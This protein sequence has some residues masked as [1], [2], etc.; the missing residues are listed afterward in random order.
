MTVINIDKQSFLFYKKV[1]IDNRKSI[2]MKIKNI[3]IKNILY[4]Y[5]THDFSNM[6]LNMQKDILNLY[7]SNERH[8]DDGI[9]YAIATSI[10][11]ISITH[12]DKLL[13]SLSRKIIFASRK[14]EIIDI[15][16]LIKKRVS[17]IINDK[18]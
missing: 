1:A 4:W 8:I 5:S 17:Q 2:A 18:H 10:F 14:S 7:S 6:H 12:N 11:L 9:K 15:L 3:A 16:Q 13:F